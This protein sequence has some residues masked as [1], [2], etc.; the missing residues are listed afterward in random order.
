MTKTLDRSGTKENLNANSAVFWAYALA[1][2]GFKLFLSTLSRWGRWGGKGRRIPGPHQQEGTLAEGSNGPYK[3][4]LYQMKIY[5]VIIIII[6]LT[7]HMISCQIEWIRV[8]SEKQRW[9]EVINYCL[10]VGI[11]F[12]KRQG[13]LNCVFKP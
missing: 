11:Y 7:T 8:T 2:E 13:M 6:V 5:K 12:V 10:Y 4:D 3:E 1:R 9:N